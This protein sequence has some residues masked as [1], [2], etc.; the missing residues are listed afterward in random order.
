MTENIISGYRGRLRKKLIKNGIIVGDIIRVK[1]DGREYQ[2][3]L[4]PRVETADDWHLVLKLRSGYNIGIKY[5]DEIEIDKIG[6][7]EKPEFRTPPLP[8]M[9]R[10]FPKINIISTGGTIA[11]RVDYVTGG[12]YSALSSRDL[13]TIVPELSE[14]A[15]IEAD[16]LYS[17]F[18]ENIATEHWKGMTNMVEEKIREGSQGI[19]ITHGTDTM[20][21]SSAALSFSLQ[22]LPVPVIFVGSQRSSDR[23]SSDAASNLV[24]VVTAAAHSPI[25]EVMVGMHEDTSDDSIVFHRGTK[26]RKC[27]TSARYAF[28]SINQ[29]PVGRYRGG[30]IEVL[31]DYNKRREDRNLQVFDDFEEGVALIKF[32]PSFDPSILDILIDKGYMGIILEGT[33]LGHVS[34]FC[35]EALER[36]K[37]EDVI[38]AMTSQCL[39][40]RIDMN[41]YSN[42]R[43]LQKRG[44]IPLEDIL[45]ETALVKLMWCLGQTKDKKE[46]SSLLMENIAGEYTE[47][48]LYGEDCR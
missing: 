2:G 40:G 18:S 38:V 47:R 34:E 41:V 13:L 27:H 31:G 15:L 24:G 39:W 43:E 45:P 46:A 12:V 25:A 20:A 1:G 21:Y 22:D 30:E 8:E 6:E 19:V 32:Y 28:Q 17:V 26:C 29:S 23:P 11:S 35:Y 9:K 42:G 48:T 16:I 33:G 5:S 3:I 37:D 7:A 44:V 14:I 10:D 4:M 36:A